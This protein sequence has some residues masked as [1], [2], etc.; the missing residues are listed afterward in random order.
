LPSHPKLASRLAHKALVAVT[1]IAATACSAN[2]T[3]EHPPTITPASA[4][5]S[6][7]V[8]GRPAGVVR[9]LNLPVTGSVFDPTTKSLVVLARATDA[10]STL[11]VFS[12]DGSSRGVDLP[13][14]SYAMTGDGRGTVYLAA[15]GGYLRVDVARGGVERAPVAGRQDTR[16]TAVA[17]RSDGRVVLGGADGGVY[18]IGADDAV[19]AELKMFAHVDALATYGDTTFVLD[20]SQTSVTTIDADGTNAQHALRAGDGATT[21]AIDPEG[22][23][24]VADTR[25]EQL[26]VFG[27][28]PLMLRQR[29][30]VRGAPYGLVGSARLAWVSE[31]A[32]NSV[33][34]YDLATGIPV[35]KVRH[36][37]VQQPNSLAYDD[38]T[39]TLYV[40]SGSG[41]G[42]QVIAGASR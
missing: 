25:G 7:L 22:R 37:T 27:S 13:A 14:T 15:D 32:T 29:Y 4:A 8:S 33:I 24:L 3:A 2:Q 12:A 19:S 18:T 30:P 20:R 21:M 26:L 28:D 23:L 41:A 11:T 34:G 16:F 5:T 35:E 17:L 9:P 40:L 1:V 39:D 6:P 38:D 31:T 10:A 42:V 36:R